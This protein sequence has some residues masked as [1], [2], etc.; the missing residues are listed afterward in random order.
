[1]TSPSVLVELRG[2]AKRFG[3]GPPALAD[4]SLAVRAG[5][6]VAFIGPSGCG[7]STLLRLVAGLAEPSSGAVRI[8]GRAP[9]DAS[10]ELAFVFQEPALLPWLDAASNVEVP[11]RL[12]GVPRATREAVRDAALRLVGLAGRESALPRELSGGQR[13]RVSLARALTLAPKLLLLDEPFGALDAMTRERLQEELLAIRAQQG[14]TALFVTHSVTEAVFLADR[15]FVVSPQP[16]RLAAEI[17]VPLPQPRVAETRSSRDYQNLV[18][19]VS[20]RL[21]SVETVAA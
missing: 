3:G 7:K 19:E 5:E 11:L 13:M 6:I 18:V 12:R 20:H 10:T 15:I 21:R 2:V 9:A 17:A 16:G 14:W 4:V 8:A 1:M